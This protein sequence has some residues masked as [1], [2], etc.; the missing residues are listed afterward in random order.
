MQQVYP[1]EEAE[2]Q[3]LLPGTGLRPYQKQS[4]A[5]MLALEAPEPDE[6]EEEQ[7][8][9]RSAAA[10]SASTM[11][12]KIKQQAPPSASPPAAAMRGGWL[13]DEVGMGKTLVVTS[14]VLAHRSRA[15][16]IA[17]G[18]FKSFLQLA[19]WGGGSKDAQAAAAMDADLQAST[20]TPVDAMGPFD[21][22]TTPDDTDD[23]GAYYN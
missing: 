14:L 22:G 9:P 17:D 20:A 19:G 23:V 5:F 16:R 10:S 12:V 4:L 3:G 8:P 1:W 18:P 15:K 11:P 21:E 6:Q 13:A 2:P 7:E